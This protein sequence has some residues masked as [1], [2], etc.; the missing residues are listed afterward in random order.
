MF[1]P[2]DLVLEDA[3]LSDILLPS[4]DL[5][6]ILL[7]APVIEVAFETQS[8]VASQ[9][10][11]IHVLS[12]PHTVDGIN[13]PPD[14]SLYGDED[15]I[16]NLPGSWRQSSVMPTGDNV[17][18]DDMD[19]EFDEGGNIVDRSRTSAVPQTPQFARSSHVGSDT[20]VQVP[21]DHKYRD[22]DGFIVSEFQSTGYVRLIWAR[23][24]M[25]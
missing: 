23:S 3:N 25:R 16:T 5:D 9:R 15:M 14:F 10:S 22:D 12:S 17:V 4:F 21:R 2:K 6:A 1:S 24:L 7:G 11:A 20:S 8:L 13:F 18:V 19:F